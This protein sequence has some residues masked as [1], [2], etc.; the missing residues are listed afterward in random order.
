[1]EVEEELAAQAHGN[2]GMGKEIVTQMLAA[3][4]I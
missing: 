3:L 2:V 4:A 1:M